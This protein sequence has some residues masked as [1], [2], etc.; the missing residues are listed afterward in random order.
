MATNSFSE[1]MAEV[2][3]TISEMNTA[4]STANG[5]AAT[6]S[7]AA[8]KANTSADNA[9]EAATKANAAATAAE[10]ETNKWSG[11][12][13][14]ATTLAAGA[15]ATMDI[16]EENGVKHLNFGIPRG[17]DGADGAK[18]DQGSSGVKF[19]LSG[20]ALYITTG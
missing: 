9:D 15:A 18:G 16:T 11:A 8:E 2:N 13:V 10:A 12:T 7:T 20:T 1:L 6:A 3:R 14:E 19:T 17:D 5:A 4:T